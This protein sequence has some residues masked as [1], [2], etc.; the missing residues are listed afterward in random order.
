M[1]ARQPRGGV[2]GG[3]GRLSALPSQPSTGFCPE[4]ELTHRPT[5]WVSS[6]SHGQELDFPNGSQE[7]KTPPANGKRDRRSAAPS[8]AGGAGSPPRRGGQRRRRRGALP[9]G[10]R[11]RHPASRVGKS[12]RPGRPGLEPAARSRGRPWGPRPAAA[13]GPGTSRQPP[14][15]QSPGASELPAARTADLPDA[16]RTVRA[17]ALGPLL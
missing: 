3:K 2:G 12:A 15:G 1:S 17:G 4:T 16:A 5:E 13:S 9:G 11:P 14:P 8:A 10:A 6:E 7:Q